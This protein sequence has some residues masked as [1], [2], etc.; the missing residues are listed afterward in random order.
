M[1]EHCVSPIPLTGK[2]IKY[3]F[4]NGSCL[5]RSEGTYRYIR[6]QGIKYGVVV[7]R[8]AGNAV[9]RNLLKRR[10]RTALKQQMM[11]FSNIW[12]MITLYNQ[13]KDYPTIVK[14]LAEALEKILG[15]NNEKNG[16]FFH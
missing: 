5:R 10:F 15:N 2:E 11:P 3:V 7:S 8:H 13:I 14:N 1:P 16:S 6:E 4:K 9:K 12:I